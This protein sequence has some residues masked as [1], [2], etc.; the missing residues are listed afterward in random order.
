ME[1]DGENAGFLLPSVILDRGLAGLGRDEAV[2]LPGPYVFQ[3]SG[4]YFRGR[5]C[6]S[7][8]FT[9]SLTWTSPPAAIIWG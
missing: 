6:R 1:A 9:S 2:G 4:G 5:L 8:G 7:P 3:A